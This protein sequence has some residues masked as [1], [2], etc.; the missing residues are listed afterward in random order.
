MP[1][2]HAADNAEG[3]FLPAGGLPRTLRTAERKLRGNEGLVNRNSW[4]KAVK[5]GNDFAAVGFPRERQRHDCSDGAFHWLLRLTMM[6]RSSSTPIVRNSWVPIRET[7][8]T[9]KPLSR[10]FL[11]L[12]A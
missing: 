2:E 9:R 5:D 8:I 7:S 6:E 10:F 11:S 4:G 3:V 1:V 12:T